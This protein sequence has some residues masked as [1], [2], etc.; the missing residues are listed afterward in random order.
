[1]QI[2][3]QE[4][5]K[6]YRLFRDIV[7]TEK[8]D[9]TNAQVCISGDGNIMAGSRNRFITPEDDNFGFAKWVQ[10]NKEDLLT[11]GSGNHYGEW[12]GLGIQRGY[13]LNE[14]KFALFN[15]GRWN[16]ENKPKCC[17]LVP[18]IYEGIF[19]TSTIREILANLSLN[20]SLVNPD[21]KFMKPEGIVIYHTQGRQLF[22]YTLDKN[23]GHKG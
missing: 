13:G 16:L 4:F 20:G 17:A 6:I 1:M 14:K 5:N 3:F 7:I 11:L 18:K 22:K 8:I 10:A 15:L 9:G 2:E 12:H 23:D 19:D 21:F